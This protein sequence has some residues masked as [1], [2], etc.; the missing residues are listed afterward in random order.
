MPAVAQGFYAPVW[1]LPDVSK[2]VATYGGLAFGAARKGGQRHH[3]GV[4][5]IA[6]RGAVVVAPEAGSVVATQRF[7]GPN[8]HALLL[9]T[10]TG[11]VILLGEVEPD[12]WADF[13]VDVGSQV[14]RGQPVARVGVN[15]GG[16]TMLHFEMY[17]EGT[18]R[19]H[20]WWQGRPEPSE[21][22]DPTVYLETAAAGDH[23]QPEP[24]DD[25]DHEHVEHDPGSVDDDDDDELSEDDA[26][27]EVTFTPGARPE[28]QW[29][30]SVMTPADFEEYWE[31]DYRPVGLWETRQVVCTS[32]GG[33]YRPGGANGVCVLPDGTQCDA[34]DFMRGHCPA[35]PEPAIKPESDV[36]ST[37]EA[38]EPD[39]VDP[40]DVLPTSDGTPWGIPSGQG[41]PD[42]KFPWLLVALVGLAWVSD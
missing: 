23:V 39:D 37:D 24:R 12:S 25:H 41:D 22:L 35:G 2:R 4:D 6:P 9:Q 40:W 1:P 7:N 18:T 11:P 16:S 5:I 31:N 28:V 3:A 26:M 30:D 32:K 42:S 13:G 14:E 15:P 20:Q 33:T 38:P 17:R 34:L 19:N 21:L 8:A 29:V 10:V 27:P 36:A